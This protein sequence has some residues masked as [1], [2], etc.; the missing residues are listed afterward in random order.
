MNCKPGEM[1]FIWQAGANGEAWA[2]GLIVR[3]LTSFMEGEYACWIIEKPLMSP[4][5]QIYTSVYD[6][7]L[8]PV[9]DPG[10]HAVDE[11]TA[12]LPPAPLPKIDPSLLP[13]KESA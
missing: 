3:C 6:G 2:D 7:V 11:S 10:D 9:R 13:E 12:W 1:A 8:K 4:A 5:G